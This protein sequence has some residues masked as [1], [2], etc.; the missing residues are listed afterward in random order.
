MGR[1][2]WLLGRT[3]GLGRR[4]DC[5]GV[6]EEIR[7]LGR[8]AVYV[9]G[10]I[11]DEAVC[12]ELIERTVRELGSIN[13]LVN[14]AGIIRR[15]PAAETSMEDWDEVIA[16]DLTAVFR[17]SQLAAKWMLAQGRPGRSEERRVGKSVD[18]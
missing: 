10:D 17:L 7:R 11:A 13:I 15:A 6:C 16:V 4:G 1:R 18:L 12:A 2:R 14:N 5:G 8:R 9:A 3:G